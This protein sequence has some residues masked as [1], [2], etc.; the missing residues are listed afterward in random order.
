MYR[1]LVS[2]CLILLMCFA[3]SACR[4]SPVLREVIYTQA[5]P[6]EEMEQE[7]LDPEDEGEEDEQFENQEDE[8]VE[9]ERD[10]SADEGL[11]GDG[12]ASEALDTEYSPNASN[13]WAASENPDQISQTEGALENPDGEAEEQETS[14]EDANEPENV[15]DDVDT[16]KYI[17]DASGRTVAIPE[18]V[19][20][21]TAVDAAAQIVE[22]LGG[23]GRLVGANRDFLSSSLAQSAFSDLTSIQGWWD[24]SGENRISDANFA[25]LLSENPDVCFEISGQNT[26]SNDQ[27]AQLEANGI[28]YVVLPPL[29]SQENLKQ[30]VSLAATVLGSHAGSGESCSAIA[31]A[32]SAWVDD[33]VAEVGSK[34]AGSSLTSLYISGWD[35]AVTYQLNGTKGV[36][37]TSGSGLAMAYSP[38]KA[39]LV[40]TFMNA[41]NVVNESTRILSTHR[42][43]D[44]V[45][46]APMFHQ[47]DPA[48]SGTQAAFYSGAGEYGSAYDLF[49][50]RMLSDTVYYQLGG[51]Q[52]PAVI[53]A[54]QETKENLEN[55]WFWQYH[56]TDENGYVNVSGESFYCGVVGEYEIYVN[57]QGMCSW[58]AGSAESPLEAYWIACKLTGAYSEE[59]V[60]NKTQEFYRQF[61]GVDLSNAQLAHIFAS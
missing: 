2:F 50:A 8:T 38:A 37:E 1:K 34:T 16:S 57:P 28:A 3:L 24:G 53:A 52:F 25:S 23:P 10:A 45:Y 42:K 44:L 18:Q 31:S 14:G 22:M 49:V 43:T 5:A 46:V 41:A 40:S 51:S 15:P 56:E 47:F 58:A 30:A 61:F 27:A 17:V 12:N 20:T 60:Y 6:V 39:Q 36:L 7:T 19:D 29:S 13:D 26:F 35:P 55:N 33:V 11:V 32:Y 21:V 54:D 9:T 59:E 48:V 4:D